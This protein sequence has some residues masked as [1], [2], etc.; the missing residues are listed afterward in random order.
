M[1]LTNEEKEFI[2]LTKSRGYQKISINLKRET[3][4]KIDEFAKIWGSLT[5]TLVI[6]SVIATG[7]GAYIEMLEKGRKQLLNKKETKNKAKLIE[8][9]KK[10]EEFKNKHSVQ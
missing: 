2:E 10:L 1:N 8:I 5:R 6:E 7:F 3:L 9:G 4:D